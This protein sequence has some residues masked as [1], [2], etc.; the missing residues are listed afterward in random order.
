MGDR[1]FWVYMTVTGWHLAWVIVAMVYAGTMPWGVILLALA[2]SALVVSLPIGLGTVWLLARA[3]A[4]N[5]VGLAIAGC[6]VG[7]AIV[8]LAAV[9]L[10]QLRA[11]VPA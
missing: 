1:L 5:R 6:V 11:R 3:G 8:F 10:G 7:P 4:R 2:V 9:V